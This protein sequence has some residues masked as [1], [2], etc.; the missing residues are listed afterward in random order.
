MMNLGRLARF[1]FGIF[2]FFWIFIWFSSVPAQEYVY[3][4]Q[5]KRDPFVPLISSAGYLVNLEPQENE[6]LHL[7]GVMYDAD[8][9]SIVIIN[10][11]LLKVGETIG[12]AIVSSIELD[13]VVIIKD[14]EK[15]ELELRREE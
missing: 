1:G 12:N 14:N 5:G 10:G 4:F 7:E 6:A 11:E 8:G 3:K 13:K 15:V 2:I 9:G